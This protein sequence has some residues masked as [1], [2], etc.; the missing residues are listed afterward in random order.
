MVKE[1]IAGAAGGNTMQKDKNPSGVALIVTLLT[2]TVFSLMAVG[3]F[4]IVVG[5][6][7]NSTSGGDNTVAFYGAEGALE[8]MSAQVATLFSHTASPTP[9]QVTALDSSPPTIPGVTY[10]SVSTQYPNGGYY[11]EYTSNGSGGIQ[12]TSGVI[13]G[14]GP[15]AGLEGVIT[16]FTLTTV[17]EGPNNT[18]VNLVRQVQEVAVPVFEF[19]IFSNNDLSF[20]AGPDF[21]FGGRV[22]TNGN[23]YLAEGPGDTLTLPAKVTAYKSVIRTQLSNGYSTSSA[24]S[25]TVNVVSTPG[26]YRALAETEGSLTGGSSSSPNSNWNT[27]SLT[28]YNGNILTSATGARQLNMAIAFQGAAPISII[29]RSEA[30]D[31]ALMQQSR[32][33]NQASLRILLSDSSNGL[34]DGTAAV[35]LDGTL[36]GS[37]NSYGYTVDACHAPLAISPGPVEPSPNNNPE[38]DNDFLTPAGTPLIGGWIEIDMQTSLG[39]WQNVTME[40]LKQGITAALGSSCGNHPVIHLEELNQYK[41]NG[42]SSP[43]TSRSAGSTN[44]TDYVPINLY[45]TREGNLRDVNDGTIHLGGVMNVIELDVGDL[46]K[47]FASDATGQQALNNDGY[48]VYF[49]DR[50]GN[51]D[52][53]ATATYGETGMYGNEDIINPASSSGAPDGTMEEPEDMDGPNAGTANWSS[54]P[55]D[56]YGGIPECVDTTPYCAPAWLTLFSLTSPPNVPASPANL[57]RQT[58]SAGQAEKNAVIF[59]RR[60]LRLVDGTLGE[61]PPLT[62][63]NCSVARGATGSGGFNVTSENPIYILGNYNANSAGGS[64]FNDQTGDCHVPAAVMGDAVTLLSNGWNDTESFTSPTLSSGRV[65]SVTYYRTAIMGG[66]TV[67]FPQPTGYSTYQDFGTDG[68][69]H[70]FLRMLED[71]SSVTLYYKGSIA[72]FYYSLQATGVYKDGLVNSVYAPP[73]RGYSFDMDF[74][75]ISTIPPGTPRFSDVNALG[76][77]QVLLPPGSTGP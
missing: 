53:A 69:V 10:A 60:V 5:E 57:T 46:Q 49:S 30:G 40:I 14:T 47:W 44:P 9:A 29:Q 22:A 43:C 27:I 67:P 66:T 18:E 56:A 6:Q 7:K 59:F 34:P 19:G 41:C 28:D 52:P 8:N 20:F 62:T 21:Q 37:G 24:Y 1:R 42:S 50:R 65:A 71:W 64:S 63:A 45:D 2:L 32:M 70:N 26:H 11:V 72:D 36:N 3:F 54:D 23:L 61:L 74:Q 31:S 33:E 73:S 17:A 25:G 77:Q 75:D 58:V 55:F 13:G 35:P 4:Y 48:I 15:L 51:Y 38:Q 12:S 39:T 16:P 76:F 68:G